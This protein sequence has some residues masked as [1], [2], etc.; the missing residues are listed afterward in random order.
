MTLGLLSLG[1]VTDLMDQAF[2]GFDY[3]SNVVVTP[4]LSDGTSPRNAVLQQSALTLRRASLSIIAETAEALTLRGYAEAKTEV[5]FV[6]YEGAVS[7]VVVVVLCRSVG[8]G[9]V[10]DVSMVLVEM[11]EPEPAGS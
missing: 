3:P 9:D 5:E 7:D 1:A 10:W 11:S 6:D 2:S 8:F 4:L